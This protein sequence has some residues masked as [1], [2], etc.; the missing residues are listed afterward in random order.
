VIGL[1][2]DDLKAILLENLGDD[3]EKYHPKKRFKITQDEIE[4]MV[5]LKK[6]G[7]IRDLLNGRAEKLFCK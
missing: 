2:I 6:Q 7:K 4:E 3:L 1:N 5:R